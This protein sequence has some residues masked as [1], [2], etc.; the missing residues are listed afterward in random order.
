MNLNIVE[1]AVACITWGDRLLVFTH[2]DFPE[3]G[4][5][6]P[7]GTIELGEWPEAAVLREA[8]E[9]TGLEGLAVVA[10]IG[11]R[12]FDMTPHGGDGIHR[13]SFYQLALDGDAPETW[14]HY[15]EHRQTAAASQSPSSSSGRRSMPCPNSAAVWGRCS[16]R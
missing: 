12:D 3:A 15:E 9:E 6:V 10:A 2:P 1:K 14:R 13:R 11:V 16:P 7:A 8:R 4:V 5:Q